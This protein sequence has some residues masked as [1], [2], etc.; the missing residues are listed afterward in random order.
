MNA[1][2]IWHDI[3]WMYRE[4]GEVSEKNVQINWKIFGQLRFTLLDRH[5]PGFKKL[6]STITDY[7]I[8]SR[9]IRLNFTN[10]IASCK[11]ITFTDIP[12]GDCPCFHGWRQ[13]RH[14]VKGVR[15]I[16][17]KETSLCPLHLYWLPSYQSLALKEDW[18]LSRQYWKKTL[19]LE[20]HDGMI[21]ASTMNVQEGERSYSVL[22]RTDSQ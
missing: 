8:D 4:W 21:L 7:L 2:L 18:S 22:F 12:T 16:G 19:L 11:R 6:Q 5:I 14:W 3:G 13:C 15:R 10:D 17:R 1:T 20:C 9:F